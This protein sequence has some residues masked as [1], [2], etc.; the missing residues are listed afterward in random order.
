MFERSTRLLAAVIF[1][2]KKCNFVERSMKGY[3]KSRPDD[4]DR[5]DRPYRVRDDTRW[6]IHQGKDRSRR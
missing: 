4:G 5:L 6:E 1:A 3:F 2:F